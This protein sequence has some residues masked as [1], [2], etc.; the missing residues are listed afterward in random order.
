MF[1]GYE[2]WPR[3]MKT[4]NLSP[5]HESSVMHDG[6]M[7]EVQISSELAQDHRNIWAAS[8]R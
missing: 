6:E 7:I 3:L 2:T 1:Y 5:D 8:I 4:Q